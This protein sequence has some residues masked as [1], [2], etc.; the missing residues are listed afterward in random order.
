MFNKNHFEDKLASYKK[1]YEDFRAKCE[2]VQQDMSTACNKKNLNDLN[3]S[4]TEWNDMKNK[5]QND[6][7]F[8]NLE[9]KEEFLKNLN[10][11]E[12]EKTYQE[13][14]TIDKCANI[15]GMQNIQSAIKKTMAKKQLSRR[16][17]CLK[18]SPIEIWSG[19][20]LEK[21]LNDMAH[22][23][24]AS[25]AAF[26]FI[27]NRTL[28]HK[29]VA[30]IIADG[31]VKKEQIDS[32]VFDCEESGYNPLLL[33]KK[34][35]KK[36]VFKRAMKE[37]MTE[38]NAEIT[39]NVN[40]V[41]ANMM[42]GKGVKQVNVDKIGKTMD[43]YSDDTKCNPAFVATPGGITGFSRLSVGSVAMVNSNIAENANAMTIDDIQQS[44]GRGMRAGN[45]FSTT[46]SR[47][48]RITQ[49][50]HDPRYMQD[51]VN[52]IINKPVHSLKNLYHR[53]VFVDK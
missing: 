15:D 21:S 30:K 34:Y 14:V 4:Y 3:I 11:E 50:I 23:N 39:A 38:F 20:T 16:D 12:I 41:I 42:G 44:M 27:V 40:D 35:N 45:T 8:I 24:M 9:F 2:K 32:F 43:N 51:S 48:V 31:T 1:E 37:V 47:I 26:N 19:I 49:H 18:K 10:I 46:S 53:D 36:N 25:T 13:V 52:R 22:V 28:C 7:H 29:F 17:Y 5:I 33:N 6:N